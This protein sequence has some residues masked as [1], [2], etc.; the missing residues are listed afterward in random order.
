MTWNVSLYP[1]VGQLVTCFSLR[2]FFPT[3]LWWG[4]KRTRFLWSKEGK[5]RRVFLLLLWGWLKKGEEQEFWTVVC[6][7]PENNFRVHCKARFQLR[8]IF[9]ALHLQG[10]FKTSISTGKCT[11]DLVSWGKGVSQVTLWKFWLQWVMLRCWQCLQL[12]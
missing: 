10:F 1:T 7:T 8:L 2:S 4:D 9:D 12:I 5:D 3:R 6:W 11:G